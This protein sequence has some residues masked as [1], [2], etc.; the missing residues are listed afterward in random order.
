[1]DPATSVVKESKENT[2]QV[3]GMDTSGVD[4]NHRSGSGA[5]QESQVE[6]GRVDR[7]SASMMEDTRGRIAV[8]EKDMEEEDTGMR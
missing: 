1:M 3:V 7:G 2:S 5:H 8:T 4:S 6:E